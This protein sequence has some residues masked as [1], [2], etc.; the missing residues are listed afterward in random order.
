[1]YV[2][3]KTNNEKIE[4]IISREDIQ[5]EKFALASN[6]DLPEV[7]LSELLQVDPVSGIYFSNSNVQVNYHLNLV[8]IHE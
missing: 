8:F 1:M 3:R 5:R 4:S 7:N 6:R 2:R